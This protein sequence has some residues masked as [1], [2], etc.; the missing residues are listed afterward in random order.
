MLSVVDREADDMPA[1]VADHQ[2]L[3]ESSGPGT[4]ASPSPRSRT[5]SAAARPS[6]ARP[7]LCSDLAGVCPGMHERDCA[8]VAA[9]RR[10]LAARD[11]VVA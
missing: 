1:V 11:E 3:I 6:P 4:C 2:Y 5:I 7:R 10:P 9:D 8:S